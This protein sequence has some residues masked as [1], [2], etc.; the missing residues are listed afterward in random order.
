M[1]K[2]LLGFAFNTMPHDWPKKKPRATFSSNKKQ[3]QNK[4]WP[5]CARFP[6]L[7]VVTL[8]FDWFTGFPASSVMSRTSTLV[9]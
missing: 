4:S 9:N 7:H 5:T 8:S 2:F 6:A 1:E 3:D